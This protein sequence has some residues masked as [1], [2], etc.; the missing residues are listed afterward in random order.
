MRGRTVL[1]AL[2]LAVGLA[3][4]AFGGVL[5]CD[6]TPNIPLPPPAVQVMSFQAGPDAGTFVLN[7]APVS[8]QSSV[9]LYVF[10]EHTMDG[11]IADT[12]A[13]GSFTTPPFQGTVGDT[14][15]IYYDAHDG[16]RSSVTCTQ[17]QL[18]PVGGLIGAFCE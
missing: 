3:A 4:V 17:L 7:G 6:A 18:V 16:S 14:V 9:R 12:N 8:G 11:A 10:D 5:A 2:R 15:E 1:S 13:D